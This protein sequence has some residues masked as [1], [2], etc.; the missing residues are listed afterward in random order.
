MYVIVVQFREVRVLPLF[1]DLTLA[2]PPIAHC[3]FVLG[4]FSLN[5]VSTIL[6]LELL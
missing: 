1:L 3:T 4:I 5:Y 2:T 6:T